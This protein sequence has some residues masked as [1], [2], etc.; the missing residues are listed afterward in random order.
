[1]TFEE[2]LDRAVALGWKTWSSTIEKGAQ[3]VNDRLRFCDRTEISPA[4]DDCEAWFLLT[5]LVLRFHGRTA[6]QGTP[7]GKT[8]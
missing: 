5:V 2:I 6:T 3:I 4:P 7:G 1:M 8:K